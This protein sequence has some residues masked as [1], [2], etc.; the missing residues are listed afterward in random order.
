MLSPEIQHIIDKLL[1]RIEILACE[2]A[3][4]TAQSDYHKKLAIHYKNKLEVVA[5]D[6]DILAAVTDDV[7]PETIRDPMVDNYIRYMNEREGD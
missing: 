2:V 5:R 6:S 1:A 7:D 4:K 3:R